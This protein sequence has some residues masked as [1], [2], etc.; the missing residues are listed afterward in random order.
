MPEDPTWHLAITQRCW[1]EDLGGGR[2]HWDAAAERIPVVAKFLELRSVAPEGQERIEGLIGVLKAPVFSL[3]SGDHRAGTWYD[4]TRE[5]VWLLGVGWGHDY[6][7]LINLGRNRRLLPTIRDYDE[8][9]AR[10]PERSDFERLGR[11]ARDLRESARLRPGRV[12]E[13][14]LIGRV[15]VRVCFE[16]VDPAVLTVA[17]SQQLRPGSER[18][19]KQWL[20]MVAQAF[21]PGVTDPFA[22][23][24]F[25]VLVDG[26]NVQGHELA[27]TGVVPDLI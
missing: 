1:D 21:F 27:L 25:A 10:M 15:N 12:I 17:I 7:H 22:A 19:P 8:I 3:H 9:A 14:D 20:L 6:D 13:G 5:V 24:P 16:S 4:E 23:Y 26:S 18:F 2:F 11:Q